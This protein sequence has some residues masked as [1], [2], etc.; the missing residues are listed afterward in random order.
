METMVQYHNRVI[1][2][3]VTGETYEGTVHISTDPRNKF[4]KMVTEDKKKVLVFEEDDP[5]WQEMET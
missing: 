3:L 1:T 4:C 2:D 5:T